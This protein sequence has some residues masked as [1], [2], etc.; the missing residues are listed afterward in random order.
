MAKYRS[1]LHQYFSGAI[2]D[3]AKLWLHSAAAIIPVWSGASRRTFS[4]LAR[5]VGM[6]WPIATASSFNR[7]GRTEATGS[8]TGIL[9]ADAASGKYYFKYSTNLAHLVYN[10]LHDA[11]AEG[12]PTVFSR[13][14]KPGPY[15]FQNAGQTLFRFF[16]ESVHL[17]NPMK[18]LVTKRI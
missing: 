12:D 17:P 9:V 14:R 4:E 8:S 5:E 2:K 1:V 11:N 15:H 7:S 13:L 18:Q 6:A 16:S 3:A 10:E